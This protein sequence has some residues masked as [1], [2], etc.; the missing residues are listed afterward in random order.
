M[1]I[2]AAFIARVTAKSSE[3]VPSHFSS[4]STASKT[5]RRI[6]I[7]PPQQKFDRVFG[8][9]A[10]AIEAFQAERI[11]EPNVGF[12]E[13]NHRYPVAAPTFLSAS[14]VTRAASQFRDGLASESTKT[15]ISDSV[16]ACK[17]ASRRVSTFWLQL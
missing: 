13:M 10:E 2:F 8:P 14:G 15:T 16:A 11:S 1:G 12:F 5:S 9:R 6:A 4:M 7:E 17:T 3:S